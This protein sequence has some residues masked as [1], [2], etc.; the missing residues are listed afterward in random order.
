MEDAAAHPAGDAREGLPHDA[1]KAAK[2]S[3]YAGE[4]VDQ[5]FSKDATAFAA[6]MEGVQEALGEHQDSVLTRQRLRNLALHTSSTE[7]AFFRGLLHALEEARAE[8]WWTARRRLRWV[9]RR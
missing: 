8:Q 5:V 3:R 6:A 1:R 7:T 2:A 4:S 9:T